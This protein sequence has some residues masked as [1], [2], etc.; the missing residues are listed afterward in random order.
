MTLLMQLRKNCVHN[1][2]DHSLF[3]SIS[4]V[5]RMTRADRMFAIACGSVKHGNKMSPLVSPKVSEYSLSRGP[6]E[7]H[8]LMYKAVV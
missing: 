4:A 6:P 7:R 5:H 1:C 3:D 8:S 2:E